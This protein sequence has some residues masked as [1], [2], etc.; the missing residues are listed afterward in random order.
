MTDS[1]EGTLSDESVRYM[2]AVTRAF[3]RDLVRCALLRS[4]GHVE[5]EDAMQA[6]RRVLESRPGFLDDLDWTER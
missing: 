5:L 2:D 1:D 4:G 6:V 3:G